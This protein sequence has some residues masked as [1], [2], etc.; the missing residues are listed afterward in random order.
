MGQHSCVVEDQYWKSMHW[1]TVPL[2]DN[3]LKT[4]RRTER[5]GMA[6]IVMARDQHI[7]STQH[8]GVQAHFD[9]QTS[10]RVAALTYSGVA[11][12]PARRSSTIRRTTVTG[13]DPGSI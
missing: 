9:Q 8:I 2:K 3:K 10:G 7:H 6:L 13:R 4:A 11:S 1:Y 5:A 12:V